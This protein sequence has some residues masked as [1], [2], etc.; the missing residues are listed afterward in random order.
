MALSPQELSNTAWAVAELSFAHEPLLAAIAAQSIKRSMELKPLEIRMPLWSLCCLHELDPAWELFE[1][2]EKFSCPEPEHGGP[3][4]RA[5]LSECEQ[6]GLSDGEMRLLSG[7]RHGSMTLPAACAATMR[8]AEA[9]GVAT[10]EREP[11]K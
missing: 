1:C 8:L 4:W 10:L 3:S 9:G 2:L 11:G 5:L 6:R 7:L